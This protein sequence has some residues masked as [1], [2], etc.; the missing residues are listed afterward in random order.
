[1]AF[2]IISNLFRRFSHDARL[3]AESLES[4]DAAAT[5]VL[6]AVGK[7]HLVN[8]MNS[9]D[10]AA[11]RK[12]LSDASTTAGKEP[13]QWNR[14]DSGMQM[15]NIS[16]GPAERASGGGAPVMVREYSEPSAQSALVESYNALSARLTGLEKAVAAVVSFLG[17]AHGESFPADSTGRNGGGERHG[18]VDDD[19]KEDGQEDSATE[20]TL[21]GHGT[22]AMNVTQFMDRLSNKSRTYPNVVSPPS[23]Q[24]A[25]SGRTRSFDDDLADLHDDALNFSDGEMI[26][27]ATLRQAL[28]H[29][30]AGVLSA[31]QFERVK[32]TVPPK[33]REALGV[34][35]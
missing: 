26:K 14:G 25:D 29:H 5:Q 18:D 31:E 9:G 4:D 30:R 12:A 17:K 8:A 20:K 32:N 16:T 23:F 22:L 1:M 13:D 10:E 28:A 19:T 24:K 34:A 21:A 7:N 11:V 6:A 2:E 15:H 35:A 3:L 33:V 27:A